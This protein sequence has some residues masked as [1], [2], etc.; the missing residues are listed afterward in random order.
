[1][2]TKHLYYKPEVWGGIECSINRIDNIFRDQLEDSGHYIRKDDIEKIANLGF[3]KMRYPVL[4]E[5]HQ[6]Q[7]DTIIDWHWISN[8]LNKLRKHNI[9]P[10]AGLLHHGSGPAFTNLLDQNFPFAL[11]RYA[12]LVAR[13]FPWLEYY[14]PVNEPL[15]TARFSGLYGHW[16][17]HDSNERSFIRMLLN[18]VK[19]IVLSMKAIRAVN[20]GA[21][22]LQ[23]EDLSKSHS[24]G[25]LSYQADYEN[26]RR[27]LTYDLLCGKVNH[28]HFFWQYFIDLGINKKD[29]FFFLD[30]SCPPD[31]MGFNYYVTSE[32]YLYEDFQN[33]YAPG[34]GNGQHQYKD[35]EA[36][37]SGHAEGLSSLLTEAWDRYRLPM[38]VTEC[39]LNCEAPQQLK[40]FQ[41]TWENCCQLNR[42]GI[43]IQAVTAWSLLGAF[44]WNSLLTQN[45]QEYES[46]AFDIRSGELRWT[47][48]ADMIKTLTDTGNCHHGLT[49]ETGW[50]QQ[51]K[52]AHLTEILS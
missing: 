37:R 43:P 38:A 8:Q 5:R 41:E 15:T 13:K 52:V 24:T 42:N 11:S 28:R 2:E 20:P 25:L 49:A 22:L 48:L 4:W 35:T 17:P 47:A 32:R 9:T 6:P 14:T 1:M 31:I 40:W 19:G 50:W 51:H 30:N 27:W 46:G 16:Y 18:Q 29:L 39:H 10:I 33:I 36:V 21:K 12:G 3:D 23:T 26:K 7:Q 45:N 34:D 44:D